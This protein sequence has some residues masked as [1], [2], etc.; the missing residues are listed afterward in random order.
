MLQN[1]PERVEEADEK[2][3]SEGVPLYEFEPIEARR[4]M[5]CTSPSVRQNEC[6]NL[7]GRVKTKIGRIYTCLI[8]L[9]MVGCGMQLHLGLLAFWN[10]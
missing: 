2:S 9:P 10:L 5:Q 4:R 3:E 7:R 6:R 1:L 8:H